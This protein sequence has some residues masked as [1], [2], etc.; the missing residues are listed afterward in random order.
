MVGFD[1]S[2]V[3]KLVEDRLSE[4][5]IASLSLSIAQGDQMLWETGFGWADRA[6]RRRAD[7]HSVYSLASISKPMTSTALMVLVGRG[8]IDLDRP[9]NDY[10]GS[11]KLTSHFGDPEGATVRRVANHSSGLPLH[12]HFF[13]EDEPACRPH[14]DETIRRY[15][16]L[17]RPPGEAYQYAN[18]GFGFLDYLIECVSGKAYADFL[19]EE[20]FIPLN[21]T[22]TAVDLGRELHPYSAT[23]YAPNGEPLPWYTFDHPGASAVWSSAH[24]LARFGQFHLRSNLTD[25]RA[26]LS[27]DAI[28]QMQLPSVRSSEGSGYGIGFRVTED[29]GGLLTTGH[30]GAMGGVRTRLILVPELH[31]SVAV[32]T[33]GG[34]H[35]LP[36]EIAAALIDTLVPGHVASRL[37]QQAR[38][39]KSPAWA[40]PQNL[41]GRWSGHVHTHNGDL[42]LRLNCQPDGDIHIAL[43]DQMTTLLNDPA[44][45]DRALS[46]RF[47]A[48]IGTDDANKHPHHLRLNLIQREDVL[49][50]PT[51]AISTPRN[52]S[53]NA[54]SYWTELT[55]E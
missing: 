50:G 53:G 17:M 1:F 24:D 47:N 13:Y 20:V 33:N 55:R 46:G 45:R 6:A 48:T 28:D 35:N 51:H 29:D 5:G 31:L 11:S 21:M 8:Q 7:E 30:D 36:V 3:E 37:K 23:R 27:D 16:H 22:R 12:C 34:G 42:T 4:T 41:L 54:L 25:Q 18:S 38:P 44:D 39:E 9:I 40:A 43:G 19:R 49:C 10:L 52:R 2:A 26:I 15:G 32:L 14:M